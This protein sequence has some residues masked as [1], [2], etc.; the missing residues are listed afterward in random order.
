MPY[1]KNE[2]KCFEEAKVEGKDRLTGKKVSTHWPRDMP[3]A[4]VMYNEWL[5][6]VQDPETGEFYHKRDKNGN[7]I[8]GTGPRHLI[9]QIVRIRTNGGIEYL[10]SNG[11]LLGYDVVGNPVRETCSNP[12]TWKRMTLHTRKNMTRRV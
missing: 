9:R 12:E 2:E 10:Y 4:Q 11:Y 1:W 6:K 7:I 3:Q 5:K 8:K